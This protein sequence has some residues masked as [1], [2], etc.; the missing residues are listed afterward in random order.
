[1]LRQRKF[2]ERVHYHYIYNKLVDFLR[3]PSFVTLNELD[4]PI[5][6]IVT[7]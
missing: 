6:W 4:S 3:H 2:V 7:T 5:N 1:M